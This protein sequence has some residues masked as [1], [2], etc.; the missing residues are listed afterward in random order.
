ME[1]I[2]SVFGTVCTN[3]ELNCIIAVTFLIMCACHVFWAKL[4]A[5]NLIEFL[6][7]IQIEHYLYVSK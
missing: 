4:N 6:K 1:G 3:T 2:S 5:H 7:I